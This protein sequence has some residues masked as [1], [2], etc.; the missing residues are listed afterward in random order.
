MTEDPGTG[1]TPW[2]D[3]TRRIRP[4]AGMT[5]GLALALAWVA[6]A[7]WIVP[8]LLLAEH[9]GP[10]VAAL[11]RFL[12]AQPVPFL[13]QDPLGQWR[14]FATAVLIAMVMHLTIVEVLR[15]F[16]RRAGGSRAASRAS[17]ALAIVAAAFLAV[18]ILSGW[19]QD[20]FIYLQIW[21]R[22]RRGDDPWFTVPGINGIAPLHAYGPLFNLLAAPAGINPL[23]PKLLFAYAYILFAIVQTKAFAAEQP[24][25]WPRAIGLAAL[26][27]SPFAWVE[28]A[29]YGHFD[30]LVGL[31]CLGAIRAWERDR[32]VRSG[33]Y[34]AAGVLLKYLPV[35]LVP[36]LSLDRGR[37]RYRFLFVTLAAIAI[38]LLIS[39]QVWGFPTFS[40]LK[41]A[42]TR[43]SAGLSIF[44]YL[45]SGHSPLHRLGIYGSLD[46]LEPL[47][48]LLAFSCVWYWSRRVRPGIEASAAV[49]VS[50]VVWLYRV[51][52]PQYQMVPFVLVAAWMLRR[53]ERLRNRTALVVAMAGYFGWVTAYD[54]NYML[55]EAWHIH[56][57]WFPHE[58]QV[59]LPAFLLGCA[60]LAA[61]ARAA[62]P[63][64]AGTGPETCADV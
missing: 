36:F 18:T 49:A 28:A 52:F 45:R 24:P 64:A 20:Y 9:P 14:E 33:L 58:T 15:R 50:T 26:F 22:T 54:V 51:G 40:P 60:Y 17:L 63:A 5:L 16:D 6:L 32:D 37:T 1:A 44:F 55:S 38:G 13:V 4:P 34:L 27:W 25:S 59:G 30:I 19:R 56:V 35:V 39:F 41:L 10:M 61:L 43:I 7:R 11:K 12:R 21:F 47:A 46:Y 62:T 29:F 31:A 48:Q 8:P 57:P 3:R 2:I 42:A 23:A 53:W